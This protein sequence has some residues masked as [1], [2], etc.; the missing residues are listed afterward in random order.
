MSRVFVLGM[1][2]LSFEVIKPLIDSGELPNFKKI[3]E[4]SMKGV[5]NSIIP[6]ASIPAWLCFSSSQNPGQIGAYYHIRDVVGSYEKEIVQIKADTEIWDVLSQHNKKV[7]IFNVPGTHPPRKVNGFFVSGFF[8]PEG[9]EYAYPP[10]I[11]EIIGENYKGIICGDNRTTETGRID[12]I[13]DRI[14]DLR[15]FMN[16]LYD[17]YPSDLFMGVYE[18]TDVL[19][20]FFWRYQDK[21]HSQ[22]KKCELNSVFID[23]YKMIDN[24]LGD[25]LKAI[26]KDTILI[27][28]SDHGFV[29]VEKNIFLNQWL[30]EQGLLKL[31]GNDII[32]KPNSKVNKIREALVDIAAKTNI[33][34][35]IPK[36]LKEKMKISLKDVDW[37]TTTCFAGFFGTI[38]LNTQMQNYDKGSYNQY[39]ENIKKALYSLKDPENGKKLISKVYLKKEIFSG[40]QMDKMPDLVAYAS[41]GYVLRG[42]IKASLIENSELSGSHAMEGVFMAM[43]Q[44]IKTGEFEQ[45]S[46]LDVAPTILHILDVP[47][48]NKMEGKVMKHIFEKDSTFNRPEKY[49]NPNKID[50]IIENIDF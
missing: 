43:G 11:K 25:I 26:D 40:D 8:I 16:S 10:E 35:Y 5:L 32:S 1:D 23:C 22:Y 3:Y 37:N 12:I 50:N 46:L 42:D 31:K 17:K 18:I 4:N 15:K 19:Q 44:G 2:G 9:K 21:T 49:S 34:K 28:V 20:H 27:L 38:F 45:A 6:N 30:L 47:I 24:H 39:C 13:K 41:K 36:I 48:P 29:K 33:R 7:G 14:K